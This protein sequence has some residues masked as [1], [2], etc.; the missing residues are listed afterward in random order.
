MR[1]KQSLIYE[2]FLQHQ[3]LGGRKKVPVV[4]GT[5]LTK[6]FLR[7]HRARQHATAILVVDLEAAFYKVVRPLALSG[8]WDDELSACMTARL[9]LPADTLHALHNNLQQPGATLTAGM[10]ARS[11][12][13][14]Q[15]V[16]TDTFFQVSS[17]E[18]R[19]Q[20]HLGTRPGDAYADVVFGYLMARILH[21]CQDQLSQLQV[22]S[23]IPDMESPV[24]FGR[25]GHQRPSPV[26]FVG[27]VWMDDLALCLWGQT[28]DAVVAKLGVATGVLLD[29][30]REH[31]MSPNLSR[32]KTEL[33]LTPKGATKQEAKRRIAIA[34]ACFNRH[35]RLV[36]QNQQLPLDKRI[37]LFQSLVMS[38]LS[39]A[40]ET[41]KL[42][43][44]QTREYVHAAIM[45]LYRRLLKAAQMSEQACWGL[46][47]QDQA[48][49]DLVQDD[50]VW[51][52]HQLANTSA[53]G[54]PAQHFE[55]WLEIMAKAG[56]T[57]LFESTQ[58]GACLKEYVTDGKMKTHLIRSTPCRTYLLS[59]G[60]RYHP[61]PGLGSSEDQQRHIEHDNK[62]PPL[63]ALGPVLPPPR[64]RD[65]NL[66]HWDMHDAIVESALTLEAEDD[67]R[68][69]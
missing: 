18:D 7:T 48:W 28:T 38:K 60:G 46:L 8:Y 6:A 12:R 35:R 50:L 44:W 23:E 16:H 22:L 9:N 57:F 56:P 63:Q 4:L 34:N 54:D 43:D 36:F 66:V 41:W 62:L 19:T 61:A 68:L 13:A 1:C 59:H 29:L 40:M 32:G 39:Y 2:A 49:L 33:I 52:W 67:F 17:Q 37:D 21:K 64:Q 11:R 55:R 47:N 69:A 58:C 65:L 14:L 24:L 45:R 51:M 30:F 20:T 3:Q 15:A 25:A 31:A 27:P 5:H 42:Q 53:L 26:P 10:D